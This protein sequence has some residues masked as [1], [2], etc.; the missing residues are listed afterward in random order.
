MYIDFFAHEGVHLLGEIAT[1]PTEPPWGALGALLRL[2]GS[3]PLRCRAFPAHPHDGPFGRVQ[4]PFLGLIFWQIGKFAD[5]M[6]VTEGDTY[7][8]IHMRPNLCA[9]GRFNPAPA[10]GF[11]PRSHT[12]R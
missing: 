2:A 7:R 11:F 1:R 9:D 3:S 12:H 10:P 8:A 5:D 6:A 4:L